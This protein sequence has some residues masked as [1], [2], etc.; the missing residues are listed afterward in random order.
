[1]M[2]VASIFLPTMDDTLTVTAY[3]G[4]AG[5][6][7]PALVS[8]EPLNGPVWVLDR[9]GSEVLFIAPRRD[10]LPQLSVG[11]FSLAL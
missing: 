11:I 3:R 2:S 6:S 8:A 7:I 10:A 9:L 1:M 5:R 4:S